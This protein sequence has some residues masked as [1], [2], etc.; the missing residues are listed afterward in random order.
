[1]KAKDKKAPEPRRALGRGLDALLPS[2]AATAKEKIDQE[3]Q[4]VSISRL[5][6][7]KGQ[8]RKRF[9]DTALNE[10]AESLKAQG[11]IQPIVVRRRGSDFEIIAGERRWRAAQR[12]GLTEV[13]VVIKDVA[14][15]TAFEWALVENLQRMDLDPIETAEAYKRLIDEHEY[16]HG[17]LAQRMGKSRTAVTNSLRLL[18]LPEAVRDRLAAG[19]LSEGHAKVLLGLSD[20]PEELSKLALETAEKKLSVREVENKLKKIKLKAD[21]AGT[22]SASTDKAAASPKGGK[23][24]SSSKNPNIRELESQLANKL[25]MAVVLRQDA[26]KQSGTVEIAFDSLDQLD[27]FLARL[28]GP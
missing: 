16:D 27:G 7:Q 28:L 6:G 24:A 3:F 4:R 14:S 15:E 8:P 5:V 2:I 21:T 10:L 26:D 12:A 18:Q 11:M 22:A 23:S 9:D 13:P 20:S 19:E 17:T 25:G 1:M